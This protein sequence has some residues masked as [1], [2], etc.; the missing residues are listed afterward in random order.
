[1]SFYQPR[2]AMMRSP[3]AVAAI[4]SHHVRCPVQALGSNPLYLPNVSF[5]R[6]FFWRGSPSTSKFHNGFLATQSL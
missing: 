1:V 6:A 3:A 2:A 5:R 4:F